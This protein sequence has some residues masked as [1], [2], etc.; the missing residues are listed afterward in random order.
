MKLSPWL[1]IC[2]LWLSCQ[3]AR[4][5]EIEPLPYRDFEVQVADECFILRIADTLRI[6]EARHL[7]GDTTAHKFPT[8]EL[9]RGH[10]G[11]NQ[12][13]SYHWDW[14]INPA[15]VEFIEIAT[16]VCDGRP[17]FV[18]TQLDYWVDT[19]RRYCPWSARLVR[20]LP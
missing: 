4:K 8:G 5:H 18:Q 16:E 1:W 19:V 14:H 13:G 15:T 10:G 12:C 17:S 2:F 7:L 11:F 6:R 3:P 20:E 9:R